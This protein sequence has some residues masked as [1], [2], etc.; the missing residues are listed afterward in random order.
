[1]FR[2]VIAFPSGATRTKDVPTEHDAR[3][4]LARAWRKY[5]VGGRDMDMMCLG[6]H[7]VE[8]ESKGKMLHKVA[9]RWQPV[10]ISVRCFK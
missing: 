7:P 3:E 4:L 2:T 9:H 10:W 1:M 8:D 6:Y 5:S